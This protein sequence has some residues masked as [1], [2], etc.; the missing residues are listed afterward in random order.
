MISSILRV[1]LATAVLL[2]QAGR[3]ALPPYAQRLAEFRAI[4]DS[5]EVVRALSDSGRPA[6][7]FDAIEHTGPDRYEV[8]AGNCLV[9][10]H[11]A[12]DPKAPHMPGPRRFVLEVGRASCR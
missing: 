12:N 6:A 9:I 7:P 8:R 1:A 11:I 2:P 3:A 5:S 10:V 4:L